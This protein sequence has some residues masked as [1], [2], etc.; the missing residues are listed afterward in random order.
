MSSPLLHVYVAP[1]KNITGRVQLFQLFL[2]GNS[3]QTVPHCYSKL[4]D[5][6]FPMGCANSAEV[7]GS[8]G[9]NV[10]E[11]NPWL[12]QFGRGKQLLGGLNV[13]ETAQRQEAAQNE[14]LK[15]GLETSLQLKAK[16]T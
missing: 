7:D 6:G 15:R 12:W 9:S 2:A 10:Y 3:T 16:G 1:V 11:V 4:N 8:C 14:R 5:T 13:E